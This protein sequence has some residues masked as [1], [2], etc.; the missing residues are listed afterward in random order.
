MSYVKELVR[1]FTLPQPSLPACHTCLPHAYPVD[2]FALSTDKSSA[3]SVFG[4]AENA[5]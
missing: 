1:S 3:H 5:S 4:A 2:L